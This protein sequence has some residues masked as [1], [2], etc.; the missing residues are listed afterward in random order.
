MSEPKWLKDKRRYLKTIKDL[1]ATIAERDKRIEELK[2]N[3]LLRLDPDG[4]VHQIQCENCAALRTRLERM[5][6]DH[7]GCLGKGRVLQ[8]L[9]GEK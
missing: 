8:A 5:D 4:S 9:E 1:K 7:C 3:P 6:K 2:E